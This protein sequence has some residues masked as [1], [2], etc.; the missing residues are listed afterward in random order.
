SSSAPKHRN[1]RLAVGLFE[2]LLHEIED[3]GC[4]RIIEFF[5]DCE[6]MIHVLNLLVARIAGHNLVHGGAMASASARLMMLSAE[7]RT[8]RTGT[9]IFSQTSPKFSFWAAVRF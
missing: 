6:P 8:T 4:Q 9:L 3:H 1:P 5:I 2:L 7:P